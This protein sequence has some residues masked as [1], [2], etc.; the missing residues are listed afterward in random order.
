M[1]DGRTYIDG[2]DHY[3]APAE[4]TLN[5]NGMPIARCGVCDQIIDHYDVGWQHSDR[6]RTL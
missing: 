1:S 3:A 4:G 6:K 2:H 5:R